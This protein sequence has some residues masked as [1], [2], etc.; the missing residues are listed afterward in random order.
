MEDR[1]SVLDGDHAAGGEGPA[2]ADAV[3]R[4]DDG[5]A[6]VARPQEVGVQGVR[7][8]PSGTVRQAATSAWAATCPPKTRGTTAARLSPR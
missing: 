4:V 6:R 3:D 2:V 5:R 8:R 1:L 7:E